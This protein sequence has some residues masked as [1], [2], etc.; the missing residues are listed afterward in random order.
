MEWR[1]VLP[2]SPNKDKANLVHPI[3]FRSTSTSLFPYIE[4]PLGVITSQSSGASP[5]PVLP[6][7]DVLLGPGASDDAANT[8]EAFLE[9]KLIKNIPGGQ[10]CLTGKYEIGGMPQV[11]C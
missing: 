8:V 4:F 1:L 9:S 11:S 10:T 7:N 2:I 5:T 3:R 6:V